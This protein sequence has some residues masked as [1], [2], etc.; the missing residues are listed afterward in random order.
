MLMTSSLETLVDNLRHLLSFSSYVQANQNLH[1]KYLCSWHWRQKELQC[2][3]VWPDR[4]IL[5]FLGNKFYYK[6]SPNVWWLFKQLWKPSLFKS[7]WRGYF[8]GNSRKNLGFFSFQHLVTLVLFT[9]IHPTP[10][11]SLF[12]RCLI[13]HLVRSSD[14]RYSQS[15]TV[16]KF[17]PNIFTCVRLS[18]PLA[19]LTRSIKCN[20]NQFP[21]LKPTSAS[22]YFLI[23]RNL[24]E[25]SRNYRIFFEGECKMVLIGLVNIGV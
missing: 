14:D 20:Q 15:H 21:V 1:R 17:H 24:P 12:V 25:R 5:E 9:L 8:L 23:L 7:I 13:V 4:A 6:S 16:L 10:R 3:S 19:L 22:Y 18:L 2:S 11:V